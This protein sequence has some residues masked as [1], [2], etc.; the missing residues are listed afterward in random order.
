MINITNVSLENEMDLVL[1][2][3]K[4]MKVAERLGLTIATQTTF[5]TAVSEIARTVI[6]HTDNGQL[7][8]CVEQNKQR[9]SLIASVEFENTI[10]FTNEDAGYYY[11]QKLVPEFHLK[12][13]E[14]GNTIEMK[15]GMPRSLRLDAVKLAALVK[16][17][18]EEEPI[19]AYEE[20]KQR[21][22]SLN[23]IALEKEEELRQSKIIDEKKTEFISIASHEIKTPI[24]IIKAYTQIALTLGDQCSEDVREF[25]TKVD[26]QTTKLQ[27]LVLQLLDVSK[28]EN[29]NLAYTKESVSLNNFILEMEAVLKNIVPHHQIIVNLSDNHV[30]SIDKI[31]MEQVFSNIIVNAAKYSDKHTDIII[32]GN[33]AQNGFVKIAFADQGIGMT[34]GSMESI[35]KKFYRD[36][37]VMTSHSGLGM[38]LYITSKIVKD[39]GG[40]IWA[41]SKEGIGSTFYITIPVA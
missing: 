9:Y 5:A 28:M 38:G 37:D 39:H 4:S 23:K 10:R 35:F 16:Y 29:G 34:A 24:T 31:R 20:I 22:Y 13:S 33:A 17:F 32:T 25:L 15:I 12:E 8:I 41:E 27:A 30:V 40:E 2:H 26:F 1:A 21:N 36:K 6:E 14:T 7:N 3:R 11:A 18:K 19:N